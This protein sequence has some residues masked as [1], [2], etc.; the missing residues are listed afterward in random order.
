MTK[1]VFK[2]GDQVRVLRVPPSV[3]AMHPKQF[4]ETI[5]I[6]ERCVGKVLRI[7][8]FSE[9][10]DLTLNVR[11]DGSQAPNCLDHTIWIEPEHVKWVN[12]APTGTPNQAPHKRD[13]NRR[14]RR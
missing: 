9:R 2:I 12:A 10:G 11:D 8:G 14:G 3:A 1:N 4:A 5:A 7:D 6:F 13:T